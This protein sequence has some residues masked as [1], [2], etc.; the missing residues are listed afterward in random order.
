[1]AAALRLSRWNAGLTTTNPSVG[2]IVVKDGAIVG[3]A[4]TAAG[5]RPHAEPQALAD[6]GDKARGAS[7]YVTLEPCSHHGRTPPCVDAIIAS[8][9]ARGVVRLTDPDPRASGRG[10]AIPLGKASCRE[11]GCQEV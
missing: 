5:G 9:I 11:R 7:L 4:V 1:M 6:A 10:L 8:G 2:C 3:R